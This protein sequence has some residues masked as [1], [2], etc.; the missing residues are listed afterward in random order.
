MRSFAARA[1]LLVAGSALV[2]GAID[3]KALVGRFNPHR[4]ESG[5]TPMMVGNGDFAFAADVTGMQT[6]LPFNTISTWSWHNFSLPTTPGQTN[7]SDFTGL[8]YWTHGRLVNYNIPNPA[9]PVISNW[10]R[11]NPQ[12]FNLGRIGLHFPGGKNVS[13]ADLAAKS[14]DLDLFEGTINSSFSL[15]GAAVRVVTVNHPAQDVVAFAVDSALLGAG[16]LGLFFDFPYADTI[17]R[18]APFVGTYNDTSLHTT[19]VVVSPGAATITHTMDATVYY[20]EIAWEGGNATVTRQDPSTHRYILMPTTQ[21][22]SSLSVSVRYSLTKGQPAIRFADVRSATVQWWSN[23]WMSGACIDVTGTTG[24]GSANATEL[25]RRLVLSQYL[26]AVN[27]AGRDPPQE[28][29]LTNNG[30]Y[31]KFL[32][33]T[34]L[35]HLAHWALWDRYE[36]L[37]RSIPSV[38]NRMLN[39]SIIRAANQGYAGARWGKM[40][41]PS[42]RS[43]PG[44]INSLLIWQ[45]PH[46]MYFAEMEYLQRPTNATLEKWSEL[47]IATADFMASYAFHNTSTGKYDLGPPLALIS[48]NTDMNATINPTF[49]LAYWHFGLKVASQWKTRQGKPIPEAWTTVANNLAPLPI[50]NGLYVN[51]EGIP[52]MWASPT[53]ACKAPGLVNIY[54]MLPPSDMPSFNVDTLAAS[55]DKVLEAWNWDNTPGWVLGMVAMTAARL[56]NG[57]VAMDFLLNDLYQFDDVGMASAAIATPPYYPT[58]SGILMAVAMMATGWTSPARGST[59][60]SRWPEGWKVVS[61]GF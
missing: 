17:K 44:D 50:E 33:E 8:D 1:L 28:M 35:F 23:F 29:G 16:G 7:I 61:E 3:R 9:E 51:Y 34:Q 52:D 20:T 31:G 60:E 30:W 54:G 18:D 21:G 25:Q 42:G 56:G 27:E 13:E 4:N 14:Q 19:S 15:S 2:C 41:D 10:L 22:S 24:A 59:L 37:E 46:L 45:Q 47:L 11:E 43:A 53:F 6:F 55:L 5:P 38:Y 39:S 36:I 32:L 12:R 57:Q 58:N 49:E 48:E 40:T 26:L